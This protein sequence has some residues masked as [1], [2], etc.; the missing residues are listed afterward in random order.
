MNHKHLCIIIFHCKSG[1]NVS[2]SIVFSGFY[3]K[4]S[5]KQVEQIV[6]LVLAS[7]QNCTSS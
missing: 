3:E 6:A 5:A 4:M 7:V 1:K 2:L